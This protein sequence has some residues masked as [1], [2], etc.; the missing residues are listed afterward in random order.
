MKKARILAWFFVLLCVSIVLLTAISM[1]K[2]ILGKLENAQTLK[3]QYQTGVDQLFTFAIKA[4]YERDKDVPNPE[5]LTKLLEER[6]RTENSRLVAERQFI[7]CLNDIEQALFLGTILL[8]S[9]VKTQVRKEI[10][11]HRD[12]ISNSSAKIKDLDRLSKFTADL[13]HKEEKMKKKKL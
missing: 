6:E 1:K 11:S 3:N 7:E 9:Q 2:K 5:I 8:S 12:Y 4:H 13:L 10:D